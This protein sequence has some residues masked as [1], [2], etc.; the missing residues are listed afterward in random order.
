[1][2]SCRIRFAVPLI[3]LSAFPFSSAATGIPVSPSAYVTL[4][5]GA[6]TERDFS[7]LLTRPFAP[8]PTADRIALIAVGREFH[9]VLDRR[10]GF[11]AEAIYA[12]HWPDGN[13]HEFGLALNVRW[14]DFPWNAHVPTTF[15]IGVGPSYVTKVPPLESRRERTSQVLNQFNLEMTADI[16]D[17]PN[18]ALVARLQHRSGVFGL[19][20]GVHGGSDYLTLGLKW[21]FGG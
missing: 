14:H 3:A 17:D 1:M 10:L 19:I 11:E 15:A 4:V 8:A 6:G 2:T 16:T 12:Y 18:L 13:F 7:E 21:R 5:Y 20:N 9:R